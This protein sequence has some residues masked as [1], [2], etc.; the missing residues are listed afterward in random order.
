ML[1]N[2]NSN[3]A[4]P[5]R[6]RQTFWS[7]HVLMGV[8]VF[9]VKRWAATLTTKFLCVCVCSLFIA[10]SSPYKIVRAARL[11][12]EVGTKVFF[13]RGTN[14][15]TKYALKF[16]PKFLSLC[17]VGPQNSCQISCKISLPPKNKTNSPTSSAGTQGEN[18]AGTS[19]K[20]GVPEKFENRKFVLNS[21]PPDS[22]PR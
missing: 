5:P 22:K 17:L 14:F 8:G 10:F 19:G 13:F 2:Y 9:P 3:V 20:F 21:C 15:L 1:Q 7:G 11:Q 4:A 6:V 16:S 12:S 18:I